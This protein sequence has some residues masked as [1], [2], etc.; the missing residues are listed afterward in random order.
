VEHPTIGQDPTK[1]TK[2]MYVVS[3]SNTLRSNSIILETSLSPTKYTP[4][5]MKLLTLER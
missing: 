2:C 4:T 1:Y 5:E 3:P